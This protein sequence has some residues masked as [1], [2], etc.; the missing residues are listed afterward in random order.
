[1][2]RAGGKQRSTRC[3]RSADHLFRAAA[4]GQKPLLLFCRRR[5]SQGLSWDSNPT[6]PGHSQAVSYYT[7]P[8]AREG[9]EAQG[10]LRLPTSASS[11][12][13]PSRP[14]PGEVEL[15]DFQRHSGVE[16]L[17]KGP[18]CSPGGAGQALGTSGSLGPCQQDWAERRSGPACDPRR[19][20][21][22]S[23]GPRLP[24]AP[25]HFPLPVGGRRAQAAG[26]WCETGNKGSVLRLR[27]VCASKS[28]PARGWAQGR[29]GPAPPQEF[30]PEPALTT[31]I[32]I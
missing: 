7:A 20:L 22:D 21:P 24:L 8:Q 3:L 16:R 32:L 11:P 17:G 12:T 4:G 6:R 25:G 31:S 23:A 2:R 29:A 27:S 1:M 13:P 14:S 30:A 15:S 10:L 19:L 18:P 26:C 28:D 9:A 5:P